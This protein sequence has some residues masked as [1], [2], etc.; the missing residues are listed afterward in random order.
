MEIKSCAVFCNG[1]WSLEVLQDDN[2]YP[3]FFRAAA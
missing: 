1:E 3:P 2:A